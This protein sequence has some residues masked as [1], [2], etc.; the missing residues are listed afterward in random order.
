MK[1]LC[2]GAAVLMLW[3]G[4]SL[5]VHG[6]ELK[7]EFSPTGEHRLQWETDLQIG[8]LYDGYRDHFYIGYRK[9]DFGIRAYQ[10]DIGLFVSHKFPVQDFIVWAGVEDVFTDWATAFIEVRQSN[11]HGG[12]YLKLS[13]DFNGASYI[14]VGVS[15]IY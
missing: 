9:G 13:Q 1:Y 12:P 5:P 2:V 10:D 6:A 8:I 3:F 4:L 14:F 7:F 15:C 11:Q